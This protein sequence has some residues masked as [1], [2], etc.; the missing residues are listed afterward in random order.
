M[1]AGQPAH[2]PHCLRIAHVVWYLYRENTV[3]VSLGW[4]CSGGWV[5]ICAGGDPGATE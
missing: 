4:L 5:E 1:V 3:C 2:S